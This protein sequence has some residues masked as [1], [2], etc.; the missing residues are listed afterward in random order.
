[1]HQCSVDPNCVR[2]CPVGEQVGILRTAESNPKRSLCLR[3]TTGCGLRWPALLTA[4][5][6]LGLLLQ[7][8]P[9]AQAAQCPN[10][11][12]VFAR[13]TFEPPGIGVTG[14][15]F[16]EALRTRLGGLTVEPYAVDYPASLDFSR[17]A[18]GVVDASHEVITLASDCPA[19]RI[20]MGGYSQG[21]AVAVY[22]TTDAVPA[23]YVLPDGLAGPLP[24]GVAQ[25]VAVVALFGKPR[26]SFVQLIDGGAPPLTIGNLFAA[27]TIDLCAPAD[28][29]CS[30]TGTDRAAHRAYPVN[31]MT[32][33]A[34]DFA[35]QRLNV[36]R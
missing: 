32:N 29:V 1:M 26:D 28:P 4:V 9:E 11:A 24:S 20:V 21:A 14:E 16:L 7:P 13:G 6:G 18:E 22:T 10:V 5:V 17:V 35:A 25:H 19:T 23:G 8:L 31:G 30:P 3:W 27:K 33:Q 15:A 12:L 2:H 36:T 34:A